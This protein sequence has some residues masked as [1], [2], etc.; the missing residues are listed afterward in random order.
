MIVD[1]ETQG[2]RCP[3]VCGYG[4]DP[5]FM[6]LR[7]RFKQLRF[8]GKRLEHNEKGL[9]GTCGKIIQGI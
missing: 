7:A 4:G 1:R 2:S 8:V 6:E 5:T 9:G 3:L